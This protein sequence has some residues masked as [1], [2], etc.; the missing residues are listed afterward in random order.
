MIRSDT[1]CG[2]FGCNGRDRYYHDSKWDGNILYPALSKSEL[3][4][5]SAL[6]RALP[7]SHCEDC[8]SPMTY[9]EWMLHVGACRVAAV[10]EWVPEAVGACDVAA[11]VRKISHV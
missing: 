3:A 8:E 4:G 1:V 5:L 11:I 6:P 9:R 7:I 2:A 10:G